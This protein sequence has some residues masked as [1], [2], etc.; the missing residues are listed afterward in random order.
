MYRTVHEHGQSFVAKF[1]IYQICFLK[2]NVVHVFNRYRT[3][4]VL[5]LKVFNLDINKH[6]LKIL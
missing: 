4:T 3:E 1:E 6:K 2:R 5:R